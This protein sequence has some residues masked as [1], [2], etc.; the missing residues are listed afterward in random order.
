MS[1]YEYLDALSN[2]ITDPEKLRLLLDIPES[3]LAIAASK[4]HISEEEGIK[5][6]R[7]PLARIVRVINYNHLVDYAS[8]EHKI[9]QRTEEK[10]CSNPNFIPFSKL[11]DSD[12]VLRMVKTEVPSGQMNPIYDSLSIEGIGV[13]PRSK[14]RVELLARHHQYGEYPH[15][16]FSHRTSIDPFDSKKYK[17]PS[18][19]TVGELKKY[20][21]S[22]SILRSLA[23]DLEVMRGGKQENIEKD[24]DLSNYEF[25]FAM[26]LFNIAIDYCEVALTIK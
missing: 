14:N 16:G 15:P 3:V 24:I 17:I 20:D 23:H 10:F 9:W 18:A 6:D 8:K 1:K 4:F 26:P 21:T 7:Y 22:H 12:R 11:S 13:I 19:V 2:T 25:Y 5:L